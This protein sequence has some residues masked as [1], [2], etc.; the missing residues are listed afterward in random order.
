MERVPIFVT[1]KEEGRKMLFLIETYYGKPNLQSTLFLE[2][3][4]KDFGYDSFVFVETPEKA[5][6][7]LYPHPLLPREDTASAHFHAAKKQAHAFNKPLLVF[8]GGDLAYRMRVDDVVLLKGSQY[9]YQLR[10][11]EIV[12][13]HWVEDLGARY[14]VTVR[15]K[16]LRPIVGFCG[17]VAPSGIVAR[18]SYILK[19]TTWDFFARIPGKGYMVVRKKGLWWR[20]RVLRALRGKS[21]IDARFIERRTFS[22]NAKTIALDPGRAREEYIKNIEESDLILAPKGDANISLRFF[23]TLS[24]G[25][26]PLL[27]DTEVVL[28]LEGV[29]DYDAFILRVPYQE[30]DTLAP[31]VTRFYEG[32]TDES[33]VH[34][35]R[36]ARDVFLTRLRY[37]SFF[38]YLFRSSLVENAARCAHEA[39]HKDSNR[40][41]VK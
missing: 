15:G 2:E 29:L 16:S 40:H 23:E 7:F 10:P 6:Y 11:N 32:L 41:K 20:K 19:N 13:P 31:I 38:N 26:V 24:L 9:R 28:P 30:V 18:I 33:F 1:E 25:R 36:L 34:M 37:D 22:G 4:P 21:G 12:M 27:I 8:A 39:T 17:W 35:Q 5:T 3:L 14:P